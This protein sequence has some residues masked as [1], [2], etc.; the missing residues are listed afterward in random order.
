MYRING[1]NLN[2]VE[3]TGTSWSDDDLICETEYTYSVAGYGN[4][5]KYV[6]EYGNSSSVD[7]TTDDC[8]VQV[9]FGSSSYRV[10]E[11]DNIDIEVKLNKTANQSLT[12]PIIVSPPGQVSEVKFIGTSTSASFSYQAPEDDNDCNDEEVEI[13]F[14]SLPSD[15]QFGS[16]SESNISIVDDEVCL[17]NPI[18]LTVTPMSLRRAKLSWTP[19]EYTDSTITEQYVV[20]VKER[21][22]DSWT[23]FPLRLEAPEIL[24]GLD[25]IIVGKGLANTP[26]FDFQVKATDPNGVR[27]DSEF[28]DFISIVDNPILNGGRANGK[29]SKGIDDDQHSI[30]LEWDDVKDATVYSLRIRELVG[31]HASTDW[32]ETAN[33]PNPDEL[34]GAPV[35][36]IYASGR[37]VE[38]SPYGFRKGKLYGFQVVYYVT[39]IV[40]DGGPQGPIERTWQVFSARDAYAWPS[41]D[42]PGNGER[43]GTYSFFGHHEDGEF[44]YIICDETFGGPPEQLPGGSF[45]PD[46]RIAQ[47]ISVITSAFEQWQDATDN[48]ITVRR[49]NNG[50]CASYDGNMAQFIM[51]DDRQNEV[52]MFN[53]SNPDKPIYSFP[54]FKSDV[55]KICLDFADDTGN[56]APACVTSFH[57]YSGLSTECDVADDTCNTAYTVFRPLGPLLIPLPFPNSIN[58][59]R[60]AELLEK[61][62]E[63]T[64]TIGEGIELVEIIFS[65]SQN[66][67]QASNAIQSVDVSFRQDRFDD[68]DLRIPTSTQ[69]N[70]CS[71]DEDSSSDDADT[72]YFAYRTALHE[73]GHALGLSN[74]DYIDLALNQSQPYH[75]AHPTIP[76]SVMNYDGEAES[77]L[78]LSET[79]HE[80]D[81]SPHPFD[82]LAIYALYQTVR[83]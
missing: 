28:S 79:L 7:V 4:G 20:E 77:R 75:A 50:E 16:P 17:S 37:L 25:E 48:F 51:D 72:E 40:E 24:I 9:M 42:F 68:G 54:E 2:N 10:D 78:G 60:I 81:C 76:D 74:F 73:A 56:F 83:P 32:P 29:N 64:I 67:R 23:E 58:R 19:A 22:S 26:S 70:I 46:P 8:P 11:G 34:Y 18:N 61:Q 80:P 52:R 30:F 12:I 31:N 65:A 1:G 15:V 47:W 82:I 41:S 71:S 5:I 49:D 66:R 35:S 63:G 55:F 39:A 45:E 57:G 38:V 69:F 21:T 36:P 14:G 3:T 27:L 33:W 43:V 44:E 13:R 62:V 59:V 53:L 6:Q